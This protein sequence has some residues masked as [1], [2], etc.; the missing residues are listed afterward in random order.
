MSL[1]ELFD[2]LTRALFTH[3]LPNIN[4]NLKIAV[5]SICY[6]EVNIVQDNF[7]LFMVA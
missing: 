2:S 5:Y 3:R 7:V 4:K 1:I 6:K